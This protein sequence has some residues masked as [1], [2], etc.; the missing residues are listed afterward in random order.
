MNS[1]NIEDMFLII[2]KFKTANCLGLLS[3]YNESQRKLLFNLGV[4]LGERWVDPFSLN[5]LMPKVLEDEKL[6]DVVLDVLY[7]LNI[8]LEDYYDIQDSIS[9]TVTRSS[10]VTCIII[11]KLF[12]FLKS[13]M[14]SK[15]ISKHDNIESIIGKINYG[16][17]KLEKIP[18]I[19]NSFCNVVSN[20]D[21]INLIFSENSRYS[22]DFIGI[23][24]LSIT[25]FN[26]RDFDLKEIIRNIK[27]CNFYHGHGL[28][29][30]TLSSIFK[31]SIRTSSMRFDKR[32]FLPNYYFL[33]GGTIYVLIK[34]KA[35][36]FTLN[37]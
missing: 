14:D 27:F 32:L 28:N 18:F 36:S 17:C 34:D 2:H 13:L 11:D 5:R 37:N 4:G 16:I 21:F 23:A 35:Y 1:I 33:K 20:K 30:Q 26:L 7:Q 10:S 29:S 3:T 25:C 12:C 24:L 15:L 6:Y 19:S 9:K 22:N 31:T 8:S